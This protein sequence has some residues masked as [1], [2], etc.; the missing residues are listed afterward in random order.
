[1]VL[2]IDAVSMI[3]LHYPNDRLFTMMRSEDRP[4]G[5]AFGPLM[6]FLQMV[7]RRIARLSTEPGI[8]NLELPHLRELI[9]RPPV[10]LDVN[11]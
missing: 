1:M 4:S 5:A 3:P 6:K 11:Q 2:N 10:C 9:E 8:H 7:Y